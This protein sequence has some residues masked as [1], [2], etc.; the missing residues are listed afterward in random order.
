M[1]NIISARACTLLLAAL[2]LGLTACPEKKP[3]SAQDEGQQPSG[4]QVDTARPRSEAVAE[5]A[6]QETSSIGTVSIDASIERRDRVISDF[7]ATVFAC[8]DADLLD[9]WADEP[10]CVSE[11][12]RQIDETSAA[13]GDD[14]TDALL[15]FHDCYT[16]IEC[17]EDVYAACEDE[18]AVSI[19]KCPE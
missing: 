4:E 16:R 7:C 3:S 15:D 9:I 6:A 5:P 17:D 18:F 10:T 8:E 2:S 12:L 19:L 11:T 13:N 14:C 1:A